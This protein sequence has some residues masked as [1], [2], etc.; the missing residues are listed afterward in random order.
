MES[1]N[2]YLDGLTIHR[3]IDDVIK[4]TYQSPIR[5]IETAMKTEIEN[6]FMN[7]VKIA[8]GLDIDKNELIRALKYDRDQ[9]RKGYE[10]AKINALEI[11]IKYVPDDDG[12]CSKAG[13]DLRELLDEIENL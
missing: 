9:Y 8:V 4:N 5:Q 12:T 6:I 7:E 10:D 13:A 1:N 11:I 2:V 3:G